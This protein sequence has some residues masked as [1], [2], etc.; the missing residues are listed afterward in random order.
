MQFK[1]TI[2]DLGR[3]TR[4]Y[5]YFTKECIDNMFANKGFK[6]KNRLTAIPIYRDFNFTNASNIIGR[7]RVKNNYPEITVEGDIQDDVFGYISDTTAITF[8]GICSASRP[9]PLPETTIIDEFE[10][11]E[12]FLSDSSAFD[13]GK[14]A[15]LK[16]DED[17]IS[18]V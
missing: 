13:S 7:C 15:A 17:E 1:A 8:A 4:N 18:E 2:G 9:R 6:E 5:N 12:M 14:V 3:P 11:T 16:K 10:I